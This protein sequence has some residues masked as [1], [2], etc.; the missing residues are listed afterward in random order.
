[1][2]LLYAACL[3]APLVGTALAYYAVRRRSIL[4][5]LGVTCFFLLGFF[6]ISSIVIWNSFLARDGEAGHNPGAGVVY[7]PLLFGFVVTLAIV[8][9]V[10]AVRVARQSSGRKRH[11]HRGPEGADFPS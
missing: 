8:L 7:V 10:F 3:G 11:P 2:S 9:V 4:F 5:G 1:M 6:A